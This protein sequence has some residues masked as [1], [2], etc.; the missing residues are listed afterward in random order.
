MPTPI[1]PDRLYQ[2]LNQTGLRAKDPV[3]YQLLYNLIGNIVNL[4]TSAS[5]SGGG[6]GSN[7]TTIEQITQIINM[8]FD[9][10]DGEI[11]PPGIQGARGADGVI[12]R[13]GISIP[14]L[15]GIEGEMGYPLPGPQ[16][17][18]GPTGAAGANG[19]NG[20]PGFDGIDGESI[21]MVQSQPIL[22][23]NATSVLRSTS[24]SYTH[25][26]FAAISFDTEQYDA[27]DMWIIGDPTKLTAKTAG[28]YYV[29]GQIGVPAGTL[30]IIFG[31]IRK[32][33]VTTDLNDT[34]AAADPSSANEIHS[35]SG[36]VDLLI[37]DYIEI[38]FGIELLAGSGTVSAVANLSIGQIAQI[39]PQ[40][41]TPGPVGAQGPQ[42]AMGMDGN[43]GQD[44][45]YQVQQCCETGE[46][47]LASL[48][49]S[50]SS[51]LDFASRNAGGKAG[52]IFQPDYDDYI[53][54]FINIV[55]ANNAVDLVYRVS[56][57]G[58]STYDSGTNY[59]FALFNFDF[60][61]SGLSGANSGQTSAKLVN[62]MANTANYSANGR[63]EM[64]NP[65]SASLYK[66]TLA[67]FAVRA[68][69]NNF[70]R[71]VTNGLY[72]ST[73]AVN[74]IRFLLS[75]GNIASGTI[76]IYGVKKP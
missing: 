30:G 21:I 9:S 31:Q 52:A 72:L 73:T 26:T 57:D 17:S 64:F 56:T 10:A 43:D 61:F 62:S 23:V 24:Q 54:K 70:Y 51:S 68:S 71:H 6:G 7:T 5:S 19:V 11:G 28:K 12:G 8:G 76:R 16:G 75:S 74:A 41:S 32:N 25:G 53:F 40:I 39:A 55:P 14:G 50:S 47:L 34:G 45:F 60:N 58:G 46:V 69:D 42:G 65:L 49:A 27:Q 48:D 22:P 37:G 59:G 20:A 67:D 4:V 3:L 2:T 63:M 18:P 33:G 35:V 15:D 38:F 1:E 13:D 36:I 29:R 66:M 44:Y